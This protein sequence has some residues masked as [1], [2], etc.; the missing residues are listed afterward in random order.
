MQ[1]GFEQEKPTQEEITDT[2]LA[3]VNNDHKLFIG[4]SR[5][6]LLQSGRNLLQRGTFR[7]NFKQEALSNHSHPVLLSLQE[8]E[9]VLETPPTTPSGPAIPPGGGI[10]QTPSAPLTPD[11]IVTPKG[12]GVFNTPQTGGVFKALPPTDEGAAGAPPPVDEAAPPV[13]EDTQPPTLTEEAPPVCPESQVLIEESG[14]CVLEEPE[15]AEDEPAPLCQEGLVP[16]E[17]SNLF[18]LEEPEVAEDEPEQ[19]EIDE[20]EQ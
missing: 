11:D 7:R 12:E 5:C 19:V 2:L 18:V 16:D 10:F 17:E 20:P 3:F 13:D 8:V 14:L 15:V 1:A 9:G 4:R 6:N